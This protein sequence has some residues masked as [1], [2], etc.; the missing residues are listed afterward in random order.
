MVLKRLL[1][2]RA[3]RSLTVLS[4]VAEAKRSVDRGHRTRG[5]LLLGVAVL[6]WKWAVLG[7]LA[8]GVVTVLRR[9]RQPAASPN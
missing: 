7:I 9:G 1:G 5:I 2:S 3:T 4:V 6:A 8:Q